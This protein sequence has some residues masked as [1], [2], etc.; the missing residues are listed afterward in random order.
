MFF[1]SGCEF[2]KAKYNK[3]MMGIDACSKTI[4]GEH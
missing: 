3:I 4:F 1:Q 2:V